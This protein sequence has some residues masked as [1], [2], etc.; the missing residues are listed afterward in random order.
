MASTWPQAVHHLTTFDFSLVGAD[1]T[2]KIWSV[3]D[4]TLVHAFEGVHTRGISDVA[5]SPDSNRLASASDDG[6]VAVYSISDQTVK[7]TLKGHTNYVFCLA[8]HP[9]G[10][11]LASGSF[12][13]SIRLWEMATGSCLRTIPAH[14]DP[15]TA[16]DF[17]PDGTLLVS[18]SYDGLMCHNNA[19][20]RLILIRFNRRLWDTNSGRCLKT[21][22]DNDNPPVTSVKFSPNGKY[23]L[24]GSL[25]NAVRLWSHQTGRCVKTLTG[26]QN[27]K[28][29][30]FPAFLDSSNTGSDCILSG[31]EDG[32][33]YAWDMGSKAVLAAEKLFEG[34]LLALGV[35]PDGTSVAVASLEPELDIVILTT[36]AA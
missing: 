5:W 24:A 16:I 33:L 11:I 23:I 22:V 12:D 19:F 4:Y 18:S 9:S 20:T 25:D 35:S 28:Y 21:L 6:T 30:C 26:H 15:V 7:W 34:P 32:K 1:R 13:E 29:C 36:T 17:S 10:N 14:S 2:V 3:P 31:S 27:I 8:F